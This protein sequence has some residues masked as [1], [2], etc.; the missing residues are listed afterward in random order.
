ME[1][2]DYSYLLREL[3]VAARDAVLRCAGGSVTHPND[4]PFSYGKSS[5]KNGPFIA[6]GS[7]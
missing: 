4:E 6:H 7:F 1:T 2:I 5:Y 3:K